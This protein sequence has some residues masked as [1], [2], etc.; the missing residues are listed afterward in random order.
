MKSQRRGMLACPVCQMVLGKPGKCPL[1]GSSVEEASA[2]ASAELEPDAVDL[3]FG[4]GQ[5]ATLEQGP[6]LLFGI[7]DAPAVQAPPEE[8]SGSSVPSP[9]EG[10]LL[11]GIE[12]APSVDSEVP[13][14]LTEGQPAKALPFRIEDATESLEE[15]PS[16]RVD[17]DSSSSLP[18]GI[19][20]APTENIPDSVKT[21]ELEDRNSPIELPY[22]I[23]HMHHTPLD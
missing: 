8:S 10:A 21:A 23:D 18:F 6:E 4:L 22:G 1:C 11:F 15:A 2:S 16:D 17:D 12:D 19:E 5:E 3:P 14:N 7:D 20:D 13:Q 9:A